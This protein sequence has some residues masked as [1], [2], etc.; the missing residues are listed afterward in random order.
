MGKRNIRVH[1]GRIPP[2]MQEVWSV[3]AI[4]VTVQKDATIM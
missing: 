1:I 4:M 2:K 3:A